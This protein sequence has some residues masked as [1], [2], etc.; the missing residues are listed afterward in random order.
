METERSIL[1][2]I[3]DYRVRILTD[4]PVSPEELSEA[5]MKLRS[6][7]ATVSADIIAKKEAKAAKPQ[8][9]LDKL[10]A[11][12]DKPKSPEGQ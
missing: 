7:R 1:D 11:L 4:Q 2:Q 9:T 8:M 12:F 6:H 5:L 10:K 3:N